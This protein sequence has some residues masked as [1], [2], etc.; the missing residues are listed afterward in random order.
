[1]KSLKAIIAEELELSEET[2]D[3][4]IGSKIEFVKTPK[5]YRLM[6]LGSGDTWKFSKGDSF[7][8]I[9]IDTDKGKEIGYLVEPIKY[10]QKVDP[11]SN[12]I[13]GEFLRDLVKKGIAI[14]K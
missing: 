6:T 4:K 13:G 3:I 7:K 5:I 8:V 12:N 14:I 9:E 11:N 2:P 1:M 10:S